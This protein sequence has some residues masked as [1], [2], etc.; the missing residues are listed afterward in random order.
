SIWKTGKGGHKEPGL[1]FKVPIIQET[2]FFPKNLLEWDGDPG[3][4]PTLDKTYIWVDVFARWRINDPLKYFEAVNNEIVAQKKLD[5]II[6][7]ATRNFITSNHLIE[8]VKSTNRRMEVDSMAMG[9]EMNLDSSHYVMKTGREAITQGIRDQAA[10][11]LL[12][13]GI[14][15]VDV[16]IKRINYV[17]EVLQTVY[18]RMI[19]ERQQIAEKFRSE[20]KGDSM[21]ISGK[22]EKEL[23][24]ISSEAYRTAQELKGKADA[25][26][27]KIYA[28]ALSRDPEFYSF[29]TTLSLYEKSMDKNTV[30]FLSTNGD[31]FKY[32][33]EHRAAK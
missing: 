12:Q 1:N 2:H 21:V 13:F 5:D 6:D 15:L 26:A 20:G 22:K 11:K 19:A 25:A 24:R 28:A 18:G 9:D 16:R 33:N 8:A 29:V 14:E 32:L 31:I 23:K 27:A 10:K 30:L 4:I 3:Q 7:P 17:D